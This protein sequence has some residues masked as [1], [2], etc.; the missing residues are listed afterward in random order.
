M[1][2]FDVV[3]WKGTLSDGSTCYSAWCSYVLGVGAQG[4]TE[5]EALEGITAMMID[6]IDNPWPDGAAL[7]DER[8]AEAEMAGLM[9]ELSD[10]GIPYRVHQVT[11]AIPETAD[12]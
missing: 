4:D 7:A 3:T 9:V 1:H 10:E 8:A 11:L 5:A 12:V 2:T 6:A